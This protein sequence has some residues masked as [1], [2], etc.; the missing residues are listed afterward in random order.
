MIYRLLDHTAIKLYH[1]YTQIYYIIV[2][3]IKTRRKT[4]YCR[5]FVYCTSYRT[6]F[7]ALQ[8]CKTVRNL[9]MRI[10]IPFMELFNK[11]SSVILNFTFSALTV[12][13]GGKI[14]VQRDASFCFT[15]GW[16]SM[17][18]EL[19]QY[20]RS[21]CPWKNLPEHVKKVFLM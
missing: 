17:N 12:I 8:F 4:F 10:I 2:Q 3:I 13:K 16:L 18:P 14:S 9:S 21:N 19:E 5:L 11:I 7:L 20:I 1:I 15:F 6:I